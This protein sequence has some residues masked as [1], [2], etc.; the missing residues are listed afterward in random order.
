ML[1]ENPRL[2][3]TRYKIW[4]RPC[5]G[6]I[7]LPSAADLGLPAGACSAHCVERQDLALVVVKALRRTVSI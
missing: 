4:S 5:Q 1:V 6:I 3:Q 7:Y 2:R